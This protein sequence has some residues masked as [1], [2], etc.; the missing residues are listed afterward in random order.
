MGPAYGPLAGALRRARYSP[1]G[2]RLTRGFALLGRFTAPM[3]R[4]FLAR[5]TPPGSTF[6]NPPTFRKWQSIRARPP[7]SYQ[8]LP[9]TPQS[10]ERHQ[11]PTVQLASAVYSWASSGARRAGVEE[12]PQSPRRNGFG[13]LSG[14]RR[15][16]FSSRWS[17]STTCRRPLPSAAPRALRSRAPTSS[18]R[19]SDRDPDRAYGP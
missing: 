15:R 17:Q 19:L 10:P 14:R 4:P 8:I 13:S 11:A 6:S 9:V 18:R 5:T 12:K 3:S 7:A 2:S 1:H 16:I